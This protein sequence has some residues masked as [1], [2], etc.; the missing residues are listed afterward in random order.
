MSLQSDLVLSIDII[1]RAARV[2]LFPAIP[3]ANLRNGDDDFV[4][5]NNHHTSLFNYVPGSTLVA[6]IT[7]DFVL[8]YLFPITI[9]STFPYNLSGL[10]IIGFGMYIAS[11]P[12]LY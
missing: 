6:S 11:N 8:R 1:Q 7:I 10:L 5:E 3:N 12:H 2:T 9:V 4:Y